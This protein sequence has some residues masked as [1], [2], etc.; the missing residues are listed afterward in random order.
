M[1]VRSMGDSI[2]FCPP[3]ISTEKD[4]QAILDCFEQSLEDTWQWFERSRGQ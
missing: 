2:A 4:I 3:L 1:I